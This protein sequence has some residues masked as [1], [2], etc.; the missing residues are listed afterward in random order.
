MYGTD[1]IKKDLKSAMEFSIREKIEQR[2]KKL[3]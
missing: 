3:K 2:I 1:Y